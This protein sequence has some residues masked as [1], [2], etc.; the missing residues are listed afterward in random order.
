M[1][2]CD[3]ALERMSLALDAPLPLEE[4]QELEEHLESCPECRAAYEALFQMEGALREL[5]ETPAP[6]ELSARVMA[7][8]RGERPRRPLPLRR[9]PWW[10]GAASLAACAVLCLGVWY[11]GAQLDRSGVILEP[12]PALSSA[13]GEA[14]TS[15]SRGLTPFS[16]ED[17]AD[18]EGEAPSAG[19]AGA[20]S[21][22]SQTR[23][24][25]QAEAPAAF[26]EESS[27]QADQAPEDSSGLLSGA[28]Q[29]DGQAESPLPQTAPEGGD[30]ETSAAS[31]EGPT[32]SAAG[33]AAPW[34]EGAALVLSQLPEEVQ[35]LLPAP[36]TWTVEA[37]GLR[38]CSVSPETLRAAAEALTRAGLDPELPEEPWTE[39]CAVALLPPEEASSGG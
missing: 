16:K 2:N 27:G 19:D 18:L 5:G 28:A 6:P 7:Q 24:A 20:D 39:P 17:G 14:E 29:T 31:P 3:K 37:D 1:L 21:P 12:A 23:S 11:G 9:R 15:I 32:V 38:W 8:V 33:A 34:G 25:A 26:S 4:R 36:E 22:S 30:A 35:A 13:G 10:K